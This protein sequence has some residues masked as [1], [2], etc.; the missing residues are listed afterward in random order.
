MHVHLPKA[1]HGL[2]EFLVEIG[3]IVIGVMIALAG[4]QLVE[5][6]HG[7][8]ELADAREALHNELSADS[9]ALLAMRAENPCSDARLQLLQS[10]SEGR[11]K[12][13]SS[14]LASMD[15]RPRLW[16]LQTAAWDVTKASG[17]AGEMPIRER[18]AYAAVYDEIGNEMGHIL[19]ER[20][21]WDLLARYAGIEQLNS[22]QARGLR[23][24][25]GAV[26]IRDD[27]RRF[28]TQSILDRIEQLGVSPA[29]GPEG[30]DPRH[31]CHS[32]ER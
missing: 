19:D 4:E 2:K 3:V 11:V 27:D 24:D 12:I 18:L 16:T 28:N 7:R 32:L 23:A 14:H 22:D 31:L 29:P 9:A 15:E 13:D 26:R 8:H 1:T 21:A 10:W 17:T 30:R 6:V 5:W 25:L 20:R